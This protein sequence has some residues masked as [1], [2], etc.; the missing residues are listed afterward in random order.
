MI[1]DGGGRSTRASCAILI[2]G[3]F[4][5]VSFGFI[6]LFMCR[7]GS[8]EKLMMF[9]TTINASRYIGLVVVLLF[10]LFGCI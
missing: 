2:S 5:F 6:R 8:V 1:I 9:T 4:F 10:L 7:C 3:F